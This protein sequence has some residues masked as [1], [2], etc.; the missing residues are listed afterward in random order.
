M[1]IR[2]QT[3]TERERIR[4]DLRREHVSIDADPGIEVTTDTADEQ[5]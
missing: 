5:P 3:I 2:K 1:I 4:V